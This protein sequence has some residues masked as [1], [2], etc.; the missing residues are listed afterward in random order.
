MRYSF[1]TIAAAVVVL[2]LLTLTACGGSNRVEDAAP[3]PE[4]LPA[5]TQPVTPTE[6]APAESVG[7]E[8]IPEADPATQTPARPPDV[9]TFN[10]SGGVIGFCDTLTVDQAGSYVF[11]TCGEAPL[12]GTLPPDDLELLQNWS[13]ALAE[14]EIVRE[15]NSGGPDNMVSELVFRGRGDEAADEVQQQ[16]I[17]DWVNGLL[18]QVRPQPVA[19]PPTPE[20][21]EVP[22]GGLCPQVK[23]PAMLLADL[24]DPSRLILADADAEGE[25][26]DIVLP[27]LPF[28]RLVTANGY[29]Y[30]PA[31]D[32]DTDTVTVWQL[33][34][35][36]AH[37]PLKFTAVT[38]EQYGPFN[39][40]VSR[41]GSRIAWA[42]TGV[43]E[44]VDPP[45]YLNSL[46]VANIDGSE[47]TTLLDQVENVEQRYLQPVRF[48]PNQ[49]DLLYALQSDR[50]G[51]A[52]F[53]YN[54]R[55]D[56][57]YSISLSGGEGQLLF[58]CPVGEDQPVTCIGDIS[59]DGSH[60]A[61]SR[62]DEG[63]VQIVGLAGEA[64]SS[65]TPPAADFVGPA[66][67]GPSGTLAF[68]SAALAEG[69]ELTTPN[70]GYLS[71]VE[72]P[73]TA[74]PDT[75]LADKT[76]A[77]IWEWLDGERL[78]YGTLD[79]AGNIGTAIVTLEGEQTELSS[80]FPLAVLR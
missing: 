61:V 18:I 67:F 3:V 77:T 4:A 36:G 28:G 24:E 11:E 15:D 68:V 78:A 46:W 64:G 37:I 39:F 2:F 51:A 34:P 55:Y 80:S 48:G 56:S 6:P 69:G 13:D 44:A 22:P 79:E 30:Y 70:P 31:L 57:L 54:G 9:V 50:G 60:L 12:S 58:A 71:L 42:Q 16:V 19:A 33:G 63:V 53:D 45:L 20:P 8:T 5:S 25:Q 7:S 23:R 74:E 52:I 43:D 29:I 26:C 1:H 62:P 73:Y 40:T 10:L 76:V 49:A 35:D 21:T 14:F 38:M 72:P 17:F 75:L 47:L 27:Q 65:L 66:V 59:P 41:D 32:P